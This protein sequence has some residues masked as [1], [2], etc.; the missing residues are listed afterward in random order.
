MMPTFY[1]GSGNVTVQVQGGAFNSPR[2]INAYSI[3]KRTTKNPR[4]YLG[5]QCA[6]LLLLLSGGRPVHVFVVGQGPKLFGLT[7][8]LPSPKLLPISRFFPVGTAIAGGGLPG[9]FVNCSYL[10]VFSFVFFTGHL[11][12]K[13]AIMPVRR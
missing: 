9:V 4:G 11:I 7:P 8:C 5:F 2:S 13:A 6:R 3:K 12:S 10:I 1:T